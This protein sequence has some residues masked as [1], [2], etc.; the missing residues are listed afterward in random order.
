MNT[1][2]PIT[3]E[4]RALNLIRDRFPEAWWAESVENC[5]DGGFRSFSVS[6]NGPTFLESHGETVRLSIT[7]CEWMKRIH[8]FDPAQRGGLFYGGLAK[9]VV[10]EK[11]NIPEEDL[12]C[13]SIN[14]SRDAPKVV[15]SVL[16]RDNL[17]KRRLVVSFANGS[18]SGV[19]IAK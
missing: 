2:T 6:M 3:D 9:K 1:T 8:G 14:L 7:P 17:R 5:D 15:E 12:D 16:L 10:A 13:G 18:P 19:T 4:W 11:F